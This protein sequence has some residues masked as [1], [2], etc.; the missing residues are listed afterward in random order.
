MKREKYGKTEWW[1]LKVEK[2]EKAAGDYARNRDVKGRAG[3][4]AAGGKPQEG[5]GGERP[6]LGCAGRGGRGPCA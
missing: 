5:K 2:K 3:A 6:G 4:G 1:I